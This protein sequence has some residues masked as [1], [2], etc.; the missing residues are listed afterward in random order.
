[1]PKVL[2]L[3]FVIIAGET[4][5][6]E[7]QSTINVFEERQQCERAGAKIDAE[8]AD[9]DVSEVKRNDDGTYCLP[10]NATFIEGK[11]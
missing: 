11:T 10:V 5:L 4:E 8:F 7:P 3:L 9:S 2:W 1:M 6:D